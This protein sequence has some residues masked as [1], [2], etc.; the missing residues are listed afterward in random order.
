[1]LDRA[2]RLWSCAEN[3]L[4]SSDPDFK[5]LIYPAKSYVQKKGSPLLYFML[6]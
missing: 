2:D 1:M 3:T 6:R 4:D 5:N